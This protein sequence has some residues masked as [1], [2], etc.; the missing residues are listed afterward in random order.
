M[1]NAIH[2]RQA[3]VG[4]GVGVDIKIPTP[5]SES[6]P[7]KTLSTPQPCRW[8]SVPVKYEIYW[9]VTSNKED[10]SWIGQPVPEI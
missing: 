1:H 6:T 10:R 8:V 7:M 3:G 4:A 5:E 2:L 9:I